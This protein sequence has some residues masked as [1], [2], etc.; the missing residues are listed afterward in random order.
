MNT[1]FAIRDSKTGLFFW[2]DRKWGGVGEFREAGLTYAK[3]GHARSAIKQRKIKE[4]FPD[5]DL[6]IVEFK[7][8]EIHAEKP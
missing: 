8:M 3:I 2:S 7:L 4:Y 1:I 5:A 6:E